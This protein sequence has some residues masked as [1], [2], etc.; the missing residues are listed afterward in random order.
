M[1]LLT[2]K[3][4]SCDTQ[5][6]NENGRISPAMISTLTSPGNQNYAGTLSPASSIANRAVRLQ[7]GPSIDIPINSSD[8]EDDLDDAVSVRE[9]LR[10]APTPYHDDGMIEDLILALQK[11]FE[12]H[13]D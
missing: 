7:A 11:T 8:D 2:P 5:V 6:S 9:R 13:Q 10:F 12:H 4:F 3:P 1:N